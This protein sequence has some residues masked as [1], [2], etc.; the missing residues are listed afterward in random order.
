[1]KDKNKI[2]KQWNHQR[3]DRMLIV[4]KKRKEYCNKL[5]LQKKGAKEYRTMDSGK[6]WDDICHEK[7]IMAAVSK[8]QWS[9]RAS[10]LNRSQLEKLVNILVNTRTKRA[11][12]QQICNRSVLTKTDQLQTNL[13]SAESVLSL[14]QTLSLNTLRVVKTPDEKQTNNRSADYL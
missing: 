2:M 8:Y 12:L 13:S 6:N 5:K 14:L 4:R 10:L 9:I 11:D 3:R 7:G 1:M